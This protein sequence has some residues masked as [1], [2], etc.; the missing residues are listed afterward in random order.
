M[1]TEKEGQP[2]T[3]EGCVGNTAR[4]E[5]NP[6]DDHQSSHDAANN[7]GQQSGQQGILHKFKLEGFNQGIYPAKLL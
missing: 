1:P 4:K 6:I 2:D 5:D 3:A 7:A